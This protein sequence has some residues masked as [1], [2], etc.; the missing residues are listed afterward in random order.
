MQLRYLITLCLLNLTTPSIITKT[1]GFTIEEIYVSPVY[2][3]TDLRAFTP[4]NKNLDSRIA[5]EGDIK[6]YLLQI[7]SE[8]KK[9]TTTEQKAKRPLP[10]KKTHQKTNKK[11]QQQTKKK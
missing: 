7:I 4:P 10:T 6:L 5:F 11:Q 9:T 8:I 2:F 1:H 3:V